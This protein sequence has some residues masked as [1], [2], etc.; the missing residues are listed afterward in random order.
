MK[1]DFWDIFIHAPRQALKSQENIR[2]AFFKCWLF[3]TEGP[4]PT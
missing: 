1:M 3:T 2:K 4:S